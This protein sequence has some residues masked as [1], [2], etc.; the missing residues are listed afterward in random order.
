MNRHSHHLFHP[1]MSKPSPVDLPSLPPSL[2]PSYAPSPRLPSSEDICSFR[3]LFLFLCLFLPPCM[4]ATPAAMVRAACPWVRARQTMR[5]KQ[6]DRKAGKEGGSRKAIQ[7]P[8]RVCFPVQR[9][10]WTLVHFYTEVGNQKKPPKNT[11]I[12][13]THQQKCVFKDAAD[14]RTFQTAA[15]PP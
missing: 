1:R 3:P 12:T 2:R 14:E 6:R 7:R 5:E 15:P 11:S 4:S 10:A 9:L 13:F 8:K